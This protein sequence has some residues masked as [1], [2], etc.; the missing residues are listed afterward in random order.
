V[1]WFP[2]KGFLD[3]QTEVRMP[4]VCLA[5][6]PQVDAHTRHTWRTVLLLRR[7]IECFVMTHSL[8]A[9]LAK[10]T[11][12]CHVLMPSALKQLQLGPCDC[13]WKNVAPCV[14]WKARRLSPKL[15][16]TFANRGCHV[17]SVTDPYSRILDFLDR[18]RY[19]FFQAAPQLYSRG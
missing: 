3:S 14:S 7:V 9:V 8:K 5:C 13:F 16:T 12:G 1:P 10:Q 2:A 4:A 11:A 18:S 19:F 15:V 17:V 6:R